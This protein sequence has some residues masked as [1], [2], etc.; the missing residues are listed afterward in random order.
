MEPLKNMGD[1]L[2][3]CDAGGT[4]TDIVLIDKEGKFTVG[5]AGTTPHNESIGFWE[6]LN[7]AFSYLKID[8]MESPD[9]F[10][11]S[12]VFSRYTGTAMLN[13]LINRKG[14]K[15]GLL[16]TKGFE[17]MLLTGRGKQ[18]IAGYT[19]PRIFHI[20]YRKHNEPLVPKKFIWGITERVDLF[21]KVII[22]LYEHEVVEAAKELMKD[23]ID[24]LAICFLQSF[25]NNAHEKQAAAIAR[26]VF[27]K[28]GKDIPVFISSEIASAIREVSRCNSTVIQ[29]YAAEPSRKQLLQIENKLK[30]SGFK[31]ELQTVLSYGNIC[32]IRHEKLY[33]TLVSGPVGGIMGAQYL[34]KYLREYNIVTSDMGGTSF[35]VG[36]ITNGIVT[37]NREP[38]IQRMWVNLPMIDINSIGAGTGTYIHID[39]ESNRIRLGPDSAGS[40]PGPVSYDQGNETPT[41]MDCDLLL[42]ILNPDYYLGGKMKLNK[43]KAYWIF[44]EKI[45]DKLG[46]NVH[47]VAE[48]IINVL[49]AQMREHIKMAVM[50]GHDPSEYIL[51]SFGGAG[52]M[53]LSGYADVNEWKGVLTTPFAAA[54]SA[55]G[56]A[57]MDYALRLQKN[58]AVVIPYKAN[59]AAKIQVGTTLNQAWEELETRAK[60]EMKKEGVSPE[61]ISF[62][63]IAYMSYLGQ[64]DDVAVPSPVGRFISG[65][66]INS[67]VAEFENIY[68]K[69]YTLLGKLPEAGYS[70][71]EV[72]IVASTPSVKPVLSKYP[73]TGKNPSKAFKGTRQV[74]NGGKWQEAML[75]EMGELE[76]GNVVEGIAIVE[77]PNTTLFIPPKLKIEVDEYKCLWLKLM[78][79]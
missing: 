38:E 77:A 44:K 34:G 33:E 56:C 73:L 1:F 24:T 23:E 79:V 42:G 59:E 75:Y 14:N 48:W 47:E 67:L 41:I 28:A 4:M 43:E 32:N 2:V 45:A 76:P 35:D 49:N 68:G 51:M 11:P 39:P 62:S 20:V 63:Y 8:F 60:E 52:P 54:F 25:R 57:C 18:A 15:V 53:H 78:E 12:I 7:D 55:Y 21:G 29:A 30:S 72:A 64:L 40:S 74:F 70:I 31:Y 6:G 3:A 26:Q 46:G 22:P 69:I 19:I 16:V 66:D 13:S 37:L 58:V 17:D 65:T 9:H 36:R 27:E 10:C 61:Q 50:V 71:N 5:K